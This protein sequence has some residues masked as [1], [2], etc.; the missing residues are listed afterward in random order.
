MLCLWLSIIVIVP[1]DIQTIDSKKEG[2]QY[3]TLVRRILNIGTEHITS[4]GKI[5]D[6]AS[7]M[8]SKLLTRPD[9]IKLGV[10]KTFLQNMSDLFVKCKEN[11]DQIFAVSGIL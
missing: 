8:V 6:Y 7:I 4:A 5:R 1:F 11:T 9:V 2:D 10:T 3:E